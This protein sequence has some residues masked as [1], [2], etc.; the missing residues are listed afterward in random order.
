VSRSFRYNH[1]PDGLWPTADSLAG[2]WSPCLLDRW[3]ISENSVP[4]ERGGSQLDKRDPVV[5]QALENVVGTET[6]DPG[7]LNPPPGR[8]QAIYDEIRRLDRAKLDEAERRRMAKV[9][10]KP[11]IDADAPASLGNVC[12]ITVTPTAILPPALVGHYTDGPAS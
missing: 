9:E 4:D 5:M 7:Y 2:S 11:K 12:R 8:I 3:L 1:R 6:L 10:A